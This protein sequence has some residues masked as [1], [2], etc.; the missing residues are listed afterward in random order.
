[1]VVGWE[2]E[3]S[4]RQRRDI[5]NTLTEDLA[6]CVRETIRGTKMAVARTEDDWQAMKAVGQARRSLAHEPT[7]GVLEEGDLEK[8]GM[9]RRLPTANQQYPRLSL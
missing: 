4:L 8:N 9:T 6:V 1:V 3:P 2:P 7:L 5:P